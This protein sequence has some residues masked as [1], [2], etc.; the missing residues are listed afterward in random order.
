[1][2]HL[3]PADTSEGVLSPLPQCF[4]LYTTY[5]LHP[6][7][8]DVHEE[9]IGL[10]MAGSIPARISEK[11]GTV[12]TP[13]VGVASRDRNWGFPTIGF[14]GDGG[15]NSQYMIHYFRCMLRSVIAAGLVRS[16]CAPSGWRS[17]QPLGQ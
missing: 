16:Q 17:C 1:M 7:L 3:L 12:R 6:L 9:E 5:I 15:S 10:D 2:A 14:L 4:Y 11:A 8:V 13:T